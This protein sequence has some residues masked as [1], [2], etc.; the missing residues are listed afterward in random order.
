M[1]E[2]VESQLAE[3]IAWKRTIEQSQAERLREMNNEIIDMFVRRGSTVSEI[4]TV[5]RMAEL[6]TT[7]NFINARRDPVELAQEA[8]KTSVR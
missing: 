2:D 7:N 4:L 3:L 8:I 5:L 6:C 1:I